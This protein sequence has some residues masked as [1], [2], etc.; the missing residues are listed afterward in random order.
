M[1]SEKIEDIPS[2]NATIKKYLVELQG[3]I[4]QNN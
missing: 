3:I 4:E 1:L 2:K